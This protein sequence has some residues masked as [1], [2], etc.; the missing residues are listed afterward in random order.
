MEI[1][2]TNYFDWIPSELAHNIFGYLTPGEL[3][4]CARTCKQFNQTINSDHFQSYINLQNILEGHYQT[5][6]LTKAPLSFLSYPSIRKDAID[7]FTCTNGEQF[8]INFQ[9]VAEHPSLSTSTC[10]LWVTKVSSGK[11]HRIKWTGIRCRVIVTRFLKKMGFRTSSI[12]QRMEKS[13]FVLLKVLII[14]AS[15]CK[16]KLRSILYT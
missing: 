16:G 15:S 5:Q 2:T 4:L 3:A 7:L 6:T 14:Q 9:Q 12:T 11:S 10:L 13:L 8:L 1:N